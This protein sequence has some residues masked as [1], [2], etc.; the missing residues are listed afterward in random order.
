MMAACVPQ[1]YIVAV[2]RCGRLPL[3]DTLRGPGI[4]PSIQGGDQVYV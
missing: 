3:R 4:H 1:Y 2:L